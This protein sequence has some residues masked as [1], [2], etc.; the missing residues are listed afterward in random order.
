[1]HD[2][3]PEM[4]GSQATQIAL[5]ETLRTAV[6]LLLVEL[7]Q[8]PAE[9]RQRQIQQ[10]QQDAAW[11]LACWGDVLMHRQARARRDRGH[12]SGCRDW[13]A[14]YRPGRQPARAGDCPCQLRTA[15]LWAWCARA[16][17]A[18][19]HQPGGVDFLGV[20]WEVR[21]DR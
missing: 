7:A 15:D 3:G 19:A 4:T 9:L 16:I 1:M 13:W 14:R 12:D 20:H 18:M 10:D 2:S 6:P 8:L 5:A 17:A 11:I 21:D